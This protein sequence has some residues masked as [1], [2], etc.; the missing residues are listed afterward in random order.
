MP[1]MDVLILPSDQLQYSNHACE[2]ESIA[3]TYT[4]RGTIESIIFH[5]RLLPSDQLQ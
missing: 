3:N 5:G 4:R 2:L 1:S